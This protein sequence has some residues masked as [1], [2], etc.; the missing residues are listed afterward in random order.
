MEVKPSSGK[1]LGSRS[2]MDAELSPYTVYPFSKVQTHQLKTLGKAKWL[3]FQKVAE[4]E[5][6]ACG[7]RPTDRHPPKAAPHLGYNGIEPCL[8]PGIVSRVGVQ[9]SAPVQEVRH[10]IRWSEQPCLAAQKTNWQRDPVLSQPR[11]NHWF[12]RIKWQRISQYFQGQTDYPKVVPHS[13]GVFT[14]LNGT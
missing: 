14:K 1:P 9:H 10:S 11:K 6:E 13:L 4:G 5:Q 2:Y 7:T 3:P 12:C 8:T